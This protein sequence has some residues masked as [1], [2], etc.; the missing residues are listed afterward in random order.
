MLGV[1]GRTDAEVGTVKDE[2][3]N[4]DSSSVLFE[5]SQDPIRSGVGVRRVREIGG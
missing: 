1:S 3:T 2:G 4:V 5:R